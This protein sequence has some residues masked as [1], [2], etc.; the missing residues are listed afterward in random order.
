MKSKEVYTPGYNETAVRYMMRRHAARDAAFL[1]PYLRKGMSLLDCGCGPGTIT[2]GLAEAVSPGHVVGLDLEES[3]IDLARSLAEER[4][5]KNVEFKVGSVYELPFLQ[6]SFD[7]VFAH[8]LFEHL[9]DPLAALA[10]LRR[11]LKPGGVAG[12]SSPDWSGNLM[13]PPNQDAQK[14]IEVY[15][16]LHIRNGG[17]PYVGRELGRLM[18]E[19]GFSAVTMIAM[20][21][22][23]EDIGLVAELLAGHLERAVKEAIELECLTLNRS[24][25]EGLCGAFR[26]WAKDATLFA[27]S[28]AEAVG[29]AE[30]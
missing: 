19:A 12:L 21:D 6:H 16:R 4:G 29:R 13:A 11:V 20:Y 23:Y 15:K 24:A 5:L 22:C 2:L 9:G 17:N 10:E 18:E 26:R 3:Q 28:F 14:F 8:A 25:I 1:L 27:Q 30:L 7:V